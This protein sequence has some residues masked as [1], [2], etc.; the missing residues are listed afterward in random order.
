MII[1][2]DANYRPIDETVKRTPLQ[3]TATTS[4][5]ASS[6]GN[7]AISIPANEVWFI[8]SWAV[9]KGADVTVSSLTFDGEDTY[10]IAAVSDTVARYG[11]VLNAEKTIAISGSNAGLAAESLEIKVDGY[12]LVF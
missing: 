2:L 5:A 9:T 3:G 11:A 4:L 8:K 10:E 6:T 12:K 7:A 1:K